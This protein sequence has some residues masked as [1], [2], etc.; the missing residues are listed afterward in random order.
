MDTI[1]ES[2]RR[3]TDAPPPTRISVDGIIAGERRRRRFLIGGSALTSVAAAGVAVVLLGQGLTGPGIAGPAPGTGATGCV[4]PTP[5]VTKQPTR[6]PV[7]PSPAPRLHTVD[8]GGPSPLVVEDTPEPENAAK[9]RIG[10]AFA[11]AL[12]SAM[13]GVP[14][15]DW[16]DASC[17]LP[18]V[19][20]YDAAFPYES[21]VIVSDAYGRGVISI[22][23]YAASSARPS[24]DDCAWHQDLPDGALAYVQTE[25]PGRVDIWRPDGTGNM[26]L[27]T[28]YAGDPLRPS[29]PAT[30]E[31]LIAIGD[32]PA[33]SMYPR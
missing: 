26:L 29:P 3:A 6:T 22:H 27:A 16:A 31:Q 13:P 15:L 32:Y 2:L 10:S 20:T 23:L 5:S 30:R 21:A 11:D 1:S 25:N 9:H 18:Q 8:T 4:A 33:L 7:D 17:P 19:I 14:F 28:E 12:H 24:C